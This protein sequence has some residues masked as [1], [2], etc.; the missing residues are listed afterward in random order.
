MVAFIQ[1]RI[2]KSICVLLIVAL[3]NLR[4]PRESKPSF[5]KVSP[6]GLAE[7]TT[8]EK[9]EIIF[10][11]PQFGEMKFIAND[12]SG[13]RLR[14]IDVYYQET[15]DQIKILALDPNRTSSC[16]PE[17]HRY[18][19]LRPRMYGLPTKRFSPRLLPL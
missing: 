5:F 17:A 8:D 7:G 3:I 4:N 19:S 9:G 18:S 6:E 13:K 16:R 15:G 2:S 14:G 1:N 11:S 12:S 10:N